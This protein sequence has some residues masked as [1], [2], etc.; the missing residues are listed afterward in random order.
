MGI[1]QEP[2]SSDILPGGDADTGPGPLH[3]DAPGDGDKPD[4]DKTLSE[5]DLE[6]ELAGKPWPV[7]SHSVVIHLSSLLLSYCLLLMLQY[8]HAF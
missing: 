4:K 7:A 1:G 3:D 6:L 2:A 5:N 8:C